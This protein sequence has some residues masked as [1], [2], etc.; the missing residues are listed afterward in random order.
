MVK[1]P[2]SLIATSIPAKSSRGPMPR[3]ALLPFL[4][5]LLAQPLSALGYADLL[6]AAAKADSS[7]RLLEI[8]AERA[9]I[10]LEKGRSSAS[11]E[12]I[13][14]S[15][16][17]L[18]LGLSS[19]GLVFSAAPGLSYEKPR[20]WGLS[21]SAPFSLSKSSSYASPS[22]L[23]SYPLIEAGDPR[24]ADLAS[25]A[26]AEKAARL[27]VARRRKEVEK[28]VAAALK[29]VMEASIDLASAR[30]E[31][32]AK[33]LAMEKA[34]RLDGIEKGGMTA[35]SLER[36]IRIAE[37]KERDSKSAL[38]LA[39]S[40]LEVLCDLRISEKDLIPPDIPA[41]SL[42]LALPPPESLAAV[43]SARE[44]VAI[45][46]LAVGEAEKKKSL[47][48]N[49]G[50]NYGIGS[51]PSSTGLGA[52]L[53]AGLVLALPGLDLSCALG[54]AIDPLTGSMGPTADLGASWKPKAT[55]G[56]GLE[57]RDRG[58]SIAEAEARVDEALA[59][60]RRSLQEL[61]RRRED[62]KSGEAD[63][64]EDLAFALEERAIYEAWRARGAVS[65][66]EYEEVLAFE[67]EARSRAALAALSRLIWRLD[68]DLLGSSIQ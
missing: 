63:I 31:V 4:L 39:A 3:L 59:A 40:S 12:T 47:G 7:L 44:S 8:E 41:P 23:F 2:E 10:A 55:A 6:A 28:E 15:S 38:S 21:F 52:G 33:K 26:A 36:E 64:A 13:A 43:K 30:R 68:L 32:E 66:A 67:A 22:L 57:A 17:S 46:R 51:L 65:D 54:F 37:R 60:A 53:S 1:P 34:R 16:G 9:G 29:T 58:L 48:L 25:L 20:S 27:A 14:L 11:A 18:S 45:L 50:A 61:E 49:L 56:E 62:L 42:D 5:A 35:L 19:D 24:L